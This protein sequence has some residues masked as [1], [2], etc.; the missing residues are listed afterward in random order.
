MRTLT[1]CKNTVYDLLYRIFT[2]KATEYGKLMESVAI[3][4]VEKKIGQTINTCRLF[5]D[6]NKPCLAASPG[7]DSLV[8]IKCPCLAKD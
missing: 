8:E 4:E 3:K 6:V 5:I 1:S 7:E 2:S